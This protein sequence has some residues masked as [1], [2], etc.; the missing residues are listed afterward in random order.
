M[1]SWVSDVGKWVCL[2]LNLHNSLT[3][4]DTVTVIQTALEMTSCNFS[5]ALN[6]LLT[7]ER[8]IILLSRSFAPVYVTDLMFFR[9][10]CRIAESD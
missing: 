1:T 8:A 4:A 10:I 7:R 2:T 9:R 6:I 3:Y 5:V